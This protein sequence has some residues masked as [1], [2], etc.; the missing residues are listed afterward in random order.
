MNQSDRIAALIDVIRAEKLSAILAFSSATHHVDWGDAISLICG[1][2]PLGPCMIAV[3]PDGE[4]RLLVSPEWDLA[5][6]REHAGA[7]AVSAASDLQQ[8]LDRFLKDARK[9]GKVGLVDLDMMPNR[10]AATVRSLLGNAAVDVSKQAYLAAARKTDDEIE[11]ARMA[12]D[13][14]ERTLTHLIDITKPGLAECDVA[15]ELKLYSKKLG[16]DDNFMMFHAGGHPLAVQPPSGRR[17]ERGDLVLAEITPSYR[18]QFTQVCRTLCVGQATDLMNEKYELVARAMRNGIGWVKP[19]VPVSQICL[20]IDEVLRDAGYG[21]YC[22]PP[23]MNRRG[24]GLGISSIRPGN[25]ALTNDTLLE[26]G[27]FFVVHPNQYIPEVGYLLCG[28]P[29]LVTETGFEILA[30]SPAALISVDA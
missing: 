15:A 17:F 22:E 21:Q 23:Y 28:E 14:A 1:F 16:A 20:G 30:K 27:M 2:K 24:H 4:I 26:P 25:I 29:V 5:R 3:S 9:G 13:I 11:N 18:G 10:F 19:G 8:E 12:T 6:A 7:D